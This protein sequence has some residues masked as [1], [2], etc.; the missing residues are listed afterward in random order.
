MATLALTGLKL[1][2]SYLTSE[3]GKEHCSQLQ[4]YVQ[5]RPGELLLASGVG[6]VAKSVLT[7]TKVEELR[8]TDSQ[9]KDLGKSGV[10]AWTHLDTPLTPE[11]Q[12]AHDR[13]GITHDN[14]NKI[15]GFGLLG[16]TLAFFGLFFYALRKAAS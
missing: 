5:T 16:G 3:Q 1:G 8:L 2:Y 13:V 4:E 15:F 12:E 10:T 14:A 11:E 6:T 9:G 7:R